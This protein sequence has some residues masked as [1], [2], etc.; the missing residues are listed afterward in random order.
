MLKLFIG[1]KNY[2]SWSMRAWVL[3]RQF[4]IDFEEV[5]VRFDGFSPDSIFKKRIGEISP[6]GQVPVLVD[7]DLAVWD[8]LAIA[9]YLAERFPEIPMWPRH[10]AHRARAR[11]ICAEM[12]GGFSALRS[13]CPMNIEARLPEVGALAWRDRPAVRADV[14]RIVSM[15]SE[16]LREHQGPMLFGHFTI[17]DAYYA[18]VVMRLMTYNLPVPPDISLYMARVAQLDGVRAWIDGAL[19]ERDFLDFEEPY[20][21]GRG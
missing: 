11:S 12:H 7:A 20:R 2:S 14:A 8:T 15:W 21:L 18:P 6:A 4:G 19:L 17:A 13:A 9:E 5:M 3:M 16:L 10:P 1:N